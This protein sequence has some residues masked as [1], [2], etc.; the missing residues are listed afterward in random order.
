MIEYKEHLLSNGLTLITHQDTTTPLA[1]INI[2]YKV[3]SRN[4]SPNR[5]GFAH[6]FE[7]L[8]FGGSK[9]V[10]DY[11]KSLQRVGAEN[12]AFTNNDITNFYVVLGAENIETALWTES[13]RMQFLNLDK[14]TLENQKK[15]VIEE[16]KQRYLNVPYGDV[17]LKLRPLSYKIHPYRWPTI[18]MK[19]EHIQ[20]ASL[21]DVESFHDR[22]YG[23]EN[24]ILTI[25]GNV[26]P[27]YALD[28]AEKW[29]G[30]IPGRNYRVQKIDQEPIQTTAQFEE[31]HSNVPLD[32]IYKTFHMPGRAK[33]KYYATDL[34]SDIL[35]RGNS[36]RLHQKLVKEKEIFNN[37]SA[38]IFGSAD[39]G[40]L[41][42]SGKINSGV[43]IDYA[44]NYLTE[45]IARLR[46][47]LQDSEIEKVKN[48]AESSAYF[49]D[50]E[51]L[52]RSISLAVANSLGKTNLVNEELKMIHKTNKNEIATSASEF[53]TISNC[54]TLHYRSAN[55]KND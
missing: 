31:V 35:G 45:T 28:L 14:T 24:A 33:E 4:E 2:L 25:A 9:H 26:D 30:Q 50:T 29:F 55:S 16:F 53:L 12:N 15:V 42:I 52:N 48:Q 19:V 37:I 36:S 51:L 40:L 38:S 43:D 23:P 21:D 20:E 46:D 32:A 8:M 49:S 7:H 11:D 6:L 18:G 34:L 44:D 1:V 27:N 47:S 13:D 39:P 10:P 22:F 17:W 54:S 5:T 41:V 3:G